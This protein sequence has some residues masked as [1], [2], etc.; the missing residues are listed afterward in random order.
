[1]EK[2]RKKKIP[3]LRAD[4]D[5]AA[6]EQLLGPEAAKAVAKENMAAW[7]ARQQ[8]RKEHCSYVGCLKVNNG[9]EKFPRCK[10]CFEERQREVLYCSQFVHFRDSLL[11]FGLTHS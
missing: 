4:P 1:V 10:K 8:T 3:S 7:K 6:M 11:A 5:L 9:A 2:N